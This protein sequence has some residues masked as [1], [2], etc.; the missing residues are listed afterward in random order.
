MKLREVDF[1]AL[2]TAAVC[3]ALG[4]VSHNALNPDGVSYLDLAARLQ[5][6]DW[7]HFVQGYWSP[8]YPILVAIIATVAGRDG[9]G[10]I[11][12][13]HL[14]NTLIALLGVAV[15]WWAARRSGNRLF[16]R[17]AF[18]A[19]LVCSA[20]APRLEAVTP[21]LLLVALVAMIGFELLFFSGNRWLR[22]GVV[23]GVAFLTKTS[24][25]PWL[26]ATL[27]VRV[28]A[29]RS[30]AQRVTV[31]KSSA[32]C[33]LV[34][35]LWL[36][37]LSIKSGAP[38]FGSAARLNACWYMRE[39]DSRSP[40]THT[41]DHQQYQTVAIGSSQARVAMLGGTVWTYPPWSDPTE[42]ATGVRT[43]GGVAPSLG[44]HLLYALKQLVLV[45]SAWSWHIFLLILLPVAWLTRR[46]GAWRELLDQRRDALVVILLGGAGVLQFV[47][48]HVEPRLIAPFVLLFTLGVLGWLC[49]LVGEPSVDLPSGQNRYLVLAFSFIGLVAAL[50]RAIVHGEDQYQVARATSER[51]QGILQSEAARNPP[52]TGPRRIAV[53][54]EVFPLLN[55]AYRLGGTIELQ[56]LRPTP[57][58][59]IQWPPADQQAFVR[60]LAAQGATEAWLSKGSGSF[61]MLPLPSR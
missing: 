51:V 13:V 48:V 10:V 44:Q 59:V 9:P 46:R 12:P 20:Q 52:R 35:A 54:G 28:V 11:G 56:V 50:P 18:A 25:W 27:V 24:M 40:D 8:F 41:G 49:G 60:W 15:I 36:I 45:I 19:L 6:A 53:I 43:F 7:Q 3:I 58:E 47:A 31:A 2:L 39:C 21:D 1:L 57:A 30:R 29:T 26:L 61:S 33:V 22:L 42:W 38:T 14:L 17:T 37:P 32:V 55:E 16:G 34:M 4:L 23:M 5:A